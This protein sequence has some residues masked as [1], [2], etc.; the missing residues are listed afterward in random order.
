MGDAAALRQLLLGLDGAPYPAY[1]EIKRA[2]EFPDFTLL[3]DHVQG[4]PF[5]DPSRVRARVPLGQ[6]GFPPHCWTAASRTL[7]VRSLL[8]RRFAAEARRASRP[9]GTGKGGLLLLDA[10]GQEV[11][12]TTAVLADADALEAR[13]AAGLPARGRRILGR[14]AAE[15]LCDRVPEVVGRSLLHASL[16]PAA[17]RR[18]ADANE[19]AQALRAQ[20]AERGMVAFMADGAVLPRRSGVDPRPLE[21]GV[22]PF[23]SPESLRVTVSLPHAGPVSGLG[24][25]RGVTLIVGGGFHGKSTLLRALELGVYDHRPGDGRE[26]VVT[27]AAAVK[28]R[29]EDGRAVAGVDI[30]PFIGDLPGGAETRRFTTQEAS[31]STSQAANIVEALEAGARVLLV[32]EDTSATNFMIR[33]HRMQELVAKDREPITPFVDKV[34]QLWEELGV[35]TVLVM[36]GSGDY[37]EAADTV[38]ALE[39]YHPRDVTAEAKTIAARYRAERR[40]EGGER[41]GAPSRRAPLGTSLDPSRGRRE[42]SVKAHGRDTLLFGTEEVDLSAVEQLVHPG[43]LRA[44]GAALLGVRRLAD[45]RRTVAEILDRVEEEVAAGGL[46]RLVDRPLGTLCAFRRFELAAALNRIRALRVAEPG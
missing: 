26:L 20:L 2:W 21:A 9:Q 18:A 25:P 7:G 28:I 3:V 37:F 44:L 36:G 40:P 1:K 4:D 15:L 33:D 41:F 8:A 14:A 24:V 38:I 22:V 34:R 42:E 39:A 46:D 31:G 43:Q 10:P 35:S 11:L 17:V 23:R 30:S 27:D 32:D 13:F 6:A 12:E 19:D 16:D 45:G 5:A 29:A